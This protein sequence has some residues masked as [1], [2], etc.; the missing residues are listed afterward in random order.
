MELS[1]KRILL[2]LKIPPPVHGSTLMN[3]RII[4]SKLIKNSFGCHYLPLTFSNNTDEIGHNYFKKILLLSRYQKQLKKL[5][6]NNTFDLVYFALSPSGMAFLKDLALILFIKKAKIPIVYH[7]HGKGTKD[8]SNRSLLHKKLVEWAFKNEHAICL[9]QHLI[10]DVRPFIS[11]QPYIV[12]N[13]I[14][15]VITDQEYQKRKYNEIPH[16]IFL[17]NFTISKGILL[18]IESLAEINESGLSFTFSLIGNPYDVS[19]EKL[20]ALI[21]SKGLKSKLS[22]IGPKYDNE[23]WNQLLMSDILVFPTF[24]KKETFGLVLLEAMQ[25]GLAVISTNIGAIPDIVNDNVNGFIVDEN[26]QKSLTQNLA[27]LIENKYKRV[28]FGKE[29]RKIFMER[30]QI[31]R[32]ENQVVKT[33]NKIIANND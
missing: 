19:S 16:L 1:K 21:D 27:V 24:Y 23:K 17:S 5:L 7:L 14:E 9:S 22:Y 33:I 31:N 13:G 4:N 6:K 28:Q 30:Y 18:F 15:C 11:N 25:A 20:K 8:F 12:P 29:G 26:D 10:Y 3:Q 32:F 2:V